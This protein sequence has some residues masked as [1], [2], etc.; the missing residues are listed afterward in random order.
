MITLTLVS[1][2]QDALDRFV[3]KHYDTEIG[4]IEKF[5]PRKGERHP[6]KSFAGIGERARFLRVFYP[7]DGGKKAA[8]RAV[9]SEILGS[10]IAKEI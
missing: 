10:V 2:P 9:V 6:W 5:K 7:E 1:R 3:V 4:F 8:I